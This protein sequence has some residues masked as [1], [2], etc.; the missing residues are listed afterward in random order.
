MKLK[1][2]YFHCLDR[3]VFV[4]L[5]WFVI[6]WTQG[7]GRTAMVIVMASATSVTIHDLTIQVVEY[8]HA[9]LLA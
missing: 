6:L 3:N 5:T 8:F 2:D 4:G 9:Y 1:S 7:N